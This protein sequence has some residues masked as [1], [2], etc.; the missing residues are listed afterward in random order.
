MRNVL[1]RLK[2]AFE[3]LQAAS[4][5][6]CINKADRQ[7]YKRAE[8]I[9]EQQEDDASESESDRASDSDIDE[10]LSVWD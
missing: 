1:V 8:Y 5:K 6:G 3:D 2:R 9:K 4:I 7:L 10:R